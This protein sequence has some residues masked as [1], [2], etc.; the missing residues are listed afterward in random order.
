MNKIM[1][2]LLLTGDKYMPEL[3]LK[4]PG[5]FALEIDLYLEKASNLKHLY[6]NKLDKACFAYDAAYFDSNKLAQIIISDKI[7]KDRTYEVARSHG[8]DG[9]QTSLA[10]MIFKF[11]NKNQELQWQARLERV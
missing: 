11:F 9:Y 1:N 3:V 8:C 10:S 4:Q 2:K 7:F 5:L 6:R